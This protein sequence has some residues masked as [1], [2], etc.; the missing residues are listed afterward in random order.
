MAIFE[1]LIGSEMNKVEAVLHEGFGGSELESHVN[2]LCLSVINAGGKRMRPALVLLASHLLPSYKEEEEN[3]CC[4]LAAGIELLNTATLIHDD[5]IDNSLMRRGK[6]TLNSTS[7]NH[8]AVL[9]GDYMFT[10]CF[11]TIKDLKKADVLNVISETLATLVTG[12]LDQLKNEGDIHISVEDYYTTIY[13]KTGAL[14]ELSASAPAIYLA[15]EEK[16]KIAKAYP[17]YMTEIFG[18]D[19]RQSYIAHIR[20]EYEKMHN[21]ASNYINSESYIGN[22]ALF[23]KDALEY[24]QES[25]NTIDKSLQ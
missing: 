11:A 2:S 6:P 22:I 17:L 18:N 20:A 7:G 10:R 16:K 12:E 23:L 1:A 24:M 19:Y 15:E 8:V 21:N 25:S 5:V 3:S 9:A 13:C 4:K 14:F